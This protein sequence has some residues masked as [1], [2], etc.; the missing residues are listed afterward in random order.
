MAEY[1]DDKTFIKGKFHSKYPGKISVWIPQDTLKEFYANTRNGKGD[2][3]F[4][5]AQKKNP[6]KSSHYAYVS[7]KT[8]S[9][10]DFGSEPEK[11]VDRM[12]SKPVAPQPEQGNIPF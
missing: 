5:V 8:S 2:I 1:K 6:G 9:I 11:P 4:V 7:K 10:P 3:S 12:E